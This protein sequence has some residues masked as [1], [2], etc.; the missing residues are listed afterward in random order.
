[1]APEAFDT[2]SVA[3]RLEEEF[4]FSPKQAEGTARLVYE[5]L[6]GNGATKDDVKA[7][8][9]K[10]DTSVKALNDKIGAVR[11]DVVAVRD[12]VVAVREEVIAVKRDLHWIKL[13]GGVIVGLLVLPL[14]TDLA[15]AI[16]G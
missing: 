12:D 4:E 1:M 15:T 16:L 8:N 5:H 11:D 3:Q 10:I 2:L 14:L 6:T 13:I 9:D 7:L